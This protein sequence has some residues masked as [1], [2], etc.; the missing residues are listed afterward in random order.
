MCDHV[1]ADQ[2]YNNNHIHY[3]Y[4]DDFRLYLD[5]DTPSMSILKTYCRKHRLTFVHLYLLLGTAGLI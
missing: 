5:Y 4:S 2:Y 1:H 3:I